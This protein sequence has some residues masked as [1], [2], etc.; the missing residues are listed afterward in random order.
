MKKALLSL[1]LA[2]LIVPIGSLNAFAVE[3][4]TGFTA[5]ADV[6]GK[7]DRIVIESDFSL[8]SNLNADHFEAT[9]CVA[10]NDSVYTSAIA[11]VVANAESGY[12]E[13]TI[14]EGAAYDTGLTC[15][16]IWSGLLVG[17][18]LSFPDGTAIVRDDALPI[19]TS[20]PEDGGSL[21]QDGGVITVSFSEEMDADT[22]VAGDVDLMAG[23]VEV[24]T[25]SELAVDGM[26]MTV[27]YPALASHTNFHLYLP[28]G[29]HSLNG[30][31]L[32]DGDI[33][34]E[35]FEPG[36]NISGASGDVTESGGSASFDVSLRSRPT[37][38]V[39]FAVSSSDVTEGTVSSAALTFDPAGDWSTPQTVTV[40]GVQDRIIDG[41]IAF[42]VTVSA[43]VSADVD[44]AAFTGDNT[45]SF[46]SIDSRVGHG[47]GYIAPSLPSGTSDGAGTPAPATPP[48]GEVLGDTTTDTS[49]SGI[50]AGDFIR[51]ASFSTVYRI[52]TD[53]KR[54]PIID[55]QTYFTYADAWDSVKFVSDETLSSYVLGTPVLPKA[56]VVLVKIQ[57][58]NSV[59]ALETNTAEETIL[60]L[61]PDEMTAK[62]V[63]GA[64]WANYVIDVEPTHFKRFVMGLKIDAKYAV[65]LLQM[66]TRV[67]LN[68]K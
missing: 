3:G 41:D 52:G 12:A 67:F 43:P 37:A 58:T 54:H 18:E 51:G 2:T 1:I 44:Y 53:M 6:N 26:S 40:T 30:E 46:T 55:E 23:S 62:Y 65:N 10:G 39:T 36:F 50:V 28:A 47:S 19:A 16:V 21:D 7:V 66:K 32:D 4:Y 8:V 57:S 61:I 64:N 25:T 20:V 60:R 13:L 48:A 29:F 34:F 24:V 42:T 5:D 15:N 33:L 56:G 17:E 31:A 27:T 68:S 49:A 35:N 11:S 63:Y 22:F 14:T 45:N 38:T 9:G 59:Y